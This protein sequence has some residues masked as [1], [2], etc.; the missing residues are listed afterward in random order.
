M[1]DLKNNSHVDIR[2]AWNL[3]NQSIKPNFQIEKKLYLQLPESDI[4]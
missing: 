2:N 3:L 4:N 1:S